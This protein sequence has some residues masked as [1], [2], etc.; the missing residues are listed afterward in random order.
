[1]STG[2]LMKLFKAQ[3]WE[4]RGNQNSTVFKSTPSPLPA[5]ATDARAAFCTA[6]QSLYTGGNF[7]RRVH[8]DFKSIPLAVR[9][10]SEIEASAKVGNR[11]Q[12]VWRVACVALTAMSK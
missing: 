6:C 12:C 8:L 1:M 11:L 4:K 2:G 5:N 7:G 9:V 10:V 3:M